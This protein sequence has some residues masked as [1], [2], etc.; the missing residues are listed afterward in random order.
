[1]SID[2]WRPAAFTSHFRK[3]DP[4]PPIDRWEAVLRAEQVT[5]YQVV[6]ALAHR[7]RLRRLLGIPAT[8]ASARG[9]SLTDRERRVRLVANT[10][11]A[12]AIKAVAG[13][14][15][16]PA[17][18]APLRARNGLPLVGPHLDWELH[19]AVAVLQTMAFEELQR[20]GWHFQPNH[21]YWPLNQLEYLRGNRGLWIEP[22]QPLEIDWD[23]DGQMKLA[24]R[25]AEYSPEL[26]DVPDGAQQQPGQFTWT[27]A[28]SGLDAYA[29]Y[30]L[31]RHLKPRH[32]IEVGAGVSSTLLARALVANGKPCE[33]TLI[34]PAPRWP[35]LGE[36]PENWKVLPKLVQHVDVEN[37]ADL[38]AGDVLFYDGSHCVRTGSD[39][40]WLFFEVLPVL[41][42]GVWIHVHDVFW[43]RD[44]W[45]DWI[46]DEGLS[47]N[48]QY[49][50]QAFLM[51]NES[52]RVRFAAKMLYHYER[53]ALEKSFAGDIV[54]AGSLWM[55]KVAT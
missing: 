30:G 50:V 51:H 22:K 55:E 53:D 7:P 47:W 52:Y 27:D 23:L 36:L 8:L 26:A 34:D 9:P 17:P 12:R 4:E 11:L 28:F 31:L 14:E 32:V 21:F 24:Q 46:F 29:Y 54:H 2:K 44:Y 1:V 18:T 48:E 5:A 19:R 13:N 41:A 42:P 43:P 33:V 40:N 20:R 10:W 3:Q 45:E 6:S 15:P 25:L 16:P 35:V 38:R 37:F 39:V 49:F